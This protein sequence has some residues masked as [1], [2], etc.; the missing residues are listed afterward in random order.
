MIRF[1]LKPTIF[2]ALHPLSKLGLVAVASV[3]VL[4]SRNLI[5]LELLGISLIGIFILGKLTNVLL[6]VSKFVLPL[7]TLICMTAFLLETPL[8]NALLAGLRLYVLALIMVFLGAT[9]QP[10]VLVRAL[11]QV[12]LPEGLAIGLLV[13]IRFIPVLGQEAMK[14][15]TAY[16]LRGGTAGVPWRYAY[17]G[18]MLPLLFK[19]CLIADDLALALRLRAFGTG[20][21]T[22]YK[23]VDW[24]L[25]DTGVLIGGGGVL[26]GL[27]WL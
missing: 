18:M 2:Q 17:R 3:V 24:R 11:Q 27:L 22:P 19:A 26:V 9:T 1:A 15:R 6:T 13:T 16:A 7:S 25:L 20:K 23:R 8:D 14:I 4:A 10:S 5:T 12:G 21:F